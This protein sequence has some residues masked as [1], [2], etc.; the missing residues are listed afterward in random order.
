[1][2]FGLTNT[3]IGVVGFALLTGGAYFKGRADM[4]AA[5]VNAANK[6]TIIFVAEERSVF[7][8]AYASQVNATMAAVQ[9]D[10]ANAESCVAALEATDTAR[11]KY[12]KDLNAAIDRGEEKAS[13]LARHLRALMDKQED[14]NAGIAGAYD[15]VD[16]DIPCRLYG[17]AETECYGDQSPASVAYGVPDLDVRDAGAGGTD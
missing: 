7:R 13:E 16:P 10:L 14:T 15:R 6:N 4:R 8:A 12:R 17:L 2:A 11:A 5:A 1:M 9:S 3:I